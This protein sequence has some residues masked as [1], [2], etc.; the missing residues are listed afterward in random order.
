MCLIAFTQDAFTSWL[1]PDQE[2]A[3]RQH[4]RDGMGYM[5]VHA[6]RVRTR[7]SLQPFLGLSTPAT[8]FAV[9]WRYATHG[10]IG[11]AATHPHWVLNKDWGD[12]YD[13]AFMHNGVLSG[14]GSTVKSDTQEYCE[15]L[16]EALREDTSLITRERFW[17]FLE[18]DT[19]GS[20]LLFCSPAIPGR[21]RATPGL[22]RWARTDNGT[23]VSNTYSLSSPRWIDYAEYDEGPSAGPYTQGW[24]NDYAY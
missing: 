18:K 17:H 3:T 11:R 2:D 23:M 10:T 7:K 9:H 5:F 4:N 20:R 12:A 8:E 24:H 14:W 15:Y 19:I 16:R 1:T 22:H 21:F 6:G 13:L